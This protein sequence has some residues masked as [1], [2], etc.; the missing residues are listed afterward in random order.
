MWAA[1]VVAGGLGGIARYWLS[2]VVQRRA[3]SSFPWGTLSVNVLGA[4]VLGLVVV[5]ADGA[6]RDV[7][8]AGFVGG[9]TTFS[10]WMVETVGLMADG[11]V[12]TRRGAIDLAATTVVGTIAFVVG[13]TVATRVA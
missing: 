9:F 7:L 10:T 2:G 8:A 12:G 3:T 13:V 1:I 4:F 11:G 5:R 6:V